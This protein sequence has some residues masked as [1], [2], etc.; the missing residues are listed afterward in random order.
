MKNIAIRIT[1]TQADALSHGYK[2]LHS[3]ARAAVDCWHNVRELAL[4]SL[5]KK[6]FSLK[7]RE[8]LRELRPPRGAG[9]N[10][11][12]VQSQGT[13]LHSKLMTLTEYEAVVLCDLIRNKKTVELT[14]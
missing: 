5:R 13:S 11:L 1:E 3:Y 14:R 6:N 7:Q 2:S 10:T 12:L 8:M 9:R 4:V